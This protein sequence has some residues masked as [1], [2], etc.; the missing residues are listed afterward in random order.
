MDEYLRGMTQTS[1]SSLYMIKKFLEVFGCKLYVA[2]KLGHAN[3]VTLRC[4]A[5]EIL[6]EYYAH[7]RNSDDEEKRNILYRQQQTL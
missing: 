2:D 7:P 5:S 4:K 3:I 6:H 1:Y